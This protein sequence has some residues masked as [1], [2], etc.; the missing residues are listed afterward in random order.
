[1]QA[2]KPGSVPIPIVIGLGPH[3]LSGHIITDGLH[4]PTHPDTLAGKNEPFPILRLR[5]LFGLSTRKVYHAS[6]VAIGAVGSYPTFSPFP[7]Q[8]GVVCFLWHFLSPTSRGLPVRKYDA[9]CCPD[10]PPPDKS[11]SDKAACGAKVRKTC[12]R[13]VT[14]SLFNG[15]LR[16]PVSGVTIFELT[17][18]SAVVI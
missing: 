13:L 14:T 18:R 16:G 12:G 9:L 8:V 1:M 10:F 4:Q 7:R 2:C 15:C 6:G 5:D 3:H 17:I 11:G